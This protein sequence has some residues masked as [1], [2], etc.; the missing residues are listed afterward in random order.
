SALALVSLLMLI[1]TAIEH[2]RCKQA[3]QWMRA[4]EDWV[5]LGHWTYSEQEWLS[6]ISRARRQGVQTGLLLVGVFGGL[7]LCFGLIFAVNAPDIAGPLIGSL[8][9][10]L[11]SLTLPFGIPQ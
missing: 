4:G 8:A 7:L 10:A 2:R 1:I 5:R 6:F 9:A 3:I 11:L